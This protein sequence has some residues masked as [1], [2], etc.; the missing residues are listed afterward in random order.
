MN[1]TITTCLYDIRRREPSTDGNVCTLNDYLERSRSMLRVRLPMVVF[2]EE[3]EIVEHVR[4]VRE[5]YGLSD[6]THIVCL[7]FDQTFFYRDLEV[8]E[9]RM[10]EFTIVNWNRHKDTPLYVLLNNNKF[11]FLQRSMEI[12][13]FGSEFFIWMD[14]GIQHCTHATEQEWQD[15]S[16]TWPSFLEQDRDHI[17]QLR[18]HTVL[19]PDNMAWKDYFKMIYHHVGGGLF[20]GHMERVREYIRLFQ[21]MWHKILYEEGWWQ[22]DEAVM[23][24]LTQ[25]YPEKFRFFYG[26]Y[27]GMLSN[28]I[29]SKKSF[30][31]VLQT[32]QRYMD[33]RRYELVEQVLSTLDWERLVGTEYY[34]KALD[35]QICQ[36]YHFRSGRLS[37]ALLDVL[38][39]HEIPTLPISNLYH[40]SDPRLVPFFARWAFQNPINQS[41][42]RRWQEIPHR[43]TFRWLPLEK[44]SKTF[45]DRQEE[46]ELP[47]DELEENPETLLKHFQCQFESFPGPMVCSLYRILETDGNKV[48][49]LW[50]HLQD[51]PQNHLVLKV[52]DFLKR[53]FPQLDF[54]MICLCA[55]HQWVAEETS[56][57]LLVFS[58]EYSIHRDMEV[59][60]Q[61]ASQFVSM[62]LKL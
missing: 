21:D 32:A 23:T 16:E 25:T 20:G 30:R 52:Y 54:Y 4:K 47:L 40:L 34:E 31:L 56:S 38:N 57:S 28:F 26:D 14:M 35:L 48:I 11:D 61:V 17:H 49:F 41:A 2:T 37:P 42:V 8:L 22:L 12:N 60:R 13:P 50:T 5:E 15:I 62:L 18:I 1:I 58:L 29:Q 59:F 43:H 33:S 44:I 24:I 53:N 45:L 19:K 6:K 10:G 36:D 9:K 3:E 39:R 51:N 27:D 7:P 46:E 55:N